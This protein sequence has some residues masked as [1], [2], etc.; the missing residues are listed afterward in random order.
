MKVI[1]PSDIDGTNLVS[2]NVP[3][4]VAVWSA[5]ETYAEG[6][7]AR[8]IQTDGSSIAYESLI[9]S[10]TASPSASPESWLE[11]GPTNPWAMFDGKYGTRTTQED[12][13]AVTVEPVGR[14]DSLALLNLTGSS[15]DVT[16]RD[17]DGN[18]IYDESFSLVSTA[19]IDNWYAWFFD[20]IDIKTELFLSDLP[21][22]YN[23]SIDVTVNYEAGTAAVGWLV[24]GRMID[25]GDTERGLRLG[26]IDYSVK[27]TDDFGN[28]QLVER[29]FSRTVD[30]KVWIQRSQVDPVYKLLSGYRATPLVWVPTEAYETSIVP[31]FF[32][33][34]SIAIEYPTYSICNLEIEGL[35]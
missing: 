7:Q 16:V 30:A 1:P 14:A 28:F 9:D 27:E 5:S 18:T 8:V 2:T 20:P 21:I 31:G 25:I 35:T 19:G 3:E 34:F 12:S 32:R 6:E 24:V 15:V 33:D 22:N 13:I 10:N 29:A 11:L 23:P 4:I 17:A 26:M